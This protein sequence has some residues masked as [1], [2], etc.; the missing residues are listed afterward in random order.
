MNGA[1]RDEPELL[2]PWDLDGL[3]EALERESHA[4]PGLSGWGTGMQPESESESE[5]AVCPV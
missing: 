2:Q 3:E 5:S 1:Q 4:F